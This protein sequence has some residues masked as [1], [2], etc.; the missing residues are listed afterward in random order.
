MK[1]KKNWKKIHH[2]TILKTR[3]GT[4]S[5]SSSWKKANLK[6]RVI[7]IHTD[8]PAQLVMVVLGHLDLQG[9]LLSTSRYLKVELDLLEKIKRL[10]QRV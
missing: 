4:I 3:V 2:D 9:D 1:S 10:G 6:V 8:H 7:A 5:L